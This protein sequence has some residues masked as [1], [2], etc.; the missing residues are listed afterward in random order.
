V[1]C[2][3]SS[4]ALLKRYTAAIGITNFPSL[5]NTGDLLYVLSPDN[6]T[7]H[8][9][10]YSDDYYQNELKKQGGWSLEM[11]DI[12]SPCLSAENWTASES[13]Q[14]ASPGNINS[15]DAINV[16][17]VSPKL[18]RAYAT[19]SM[20]IRLIF[21]EPLDSTIASN[22]FCYELDENIGKP[23]LVSVEAPLFNRVNLLLNHPLKR[24]KTYSISIS[25]IVDCIQNQ[26]ATYNHSNVGLDEYADSLDLVVNEILFNPKPYGYDYVE[27][28]NR[29]NKIINL[30]N[31]YLAN[32]NSQNTIDNIT[33]IVSED[34]LI[35]PNA[36]IVVTENPKQ[37]TQNYFVPNPESILRLENMPSFGDDD[38]V[39]VL[40]NEQGKIIDI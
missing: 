32:L 34:Y 18:L 19:D 35:F 6:K 7:I 36:Y 31:I 24:N 2:S 8:A 3:G 26:I 5:N 10:E 20:H 1:I 17:D 21:N 39:V 33:P 38:G 28:Y 23:Y 40:L 14:G 29:S 12:N 15:V 30:K 4:L 37:T 25:G 9:V 27:L 16:D 11:M 22:P 13:T